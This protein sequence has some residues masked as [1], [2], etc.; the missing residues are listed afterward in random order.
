MTW[1]PAPPIGG[2]T[3]LLILCV[4]LQL[5]SLTGIVRAGA[6]CYCTC[7]HCFFV[8]QS[9]CAAMHADVYERLTPRGKKATFTT[10]LTTQVGFSITYQCTP[11]RSS[12]CFLL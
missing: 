11:N 9:K 3:L 7:L 12:S 2:T 1:C 10:L 5:E 4:S 8:L 6:A